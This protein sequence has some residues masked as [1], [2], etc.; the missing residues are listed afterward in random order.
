MI[1]IFL[2][3]LP[4]L[5]AVLPAQGQVGYFTL[6]DGTFRWFEGT[7]M[8]NGV[9]TPTLF[10]RIVDDEGN[11]TRI[12]VHSY[13]PDHVQLNLYRGTHYLKLDT[14]NQKVVS[15]T[16]F[17]ECCV[18]A[19]EGY[20][21]G[22]YQSWGGY[23]YYLVGSS[24][25][26]LTVYKH[27]PGTAKDRST[28]WNTWDFGAALQE[29]AYRFING[30]RR[31]KDEYYWIMYTDGENP[32]STL[33]CSTYQRPDDGVWYYSRLQGNWDTSY[34]CP[35]SSDT[36]DAN[37]QKPAGTAALQMAVAKYDSAATI[38]NR[39]A[40]TGL[41]KVTFFGSYSYNSSAHEIT[42]S[43]TLPV[44]D[45]KMGDSAYVGYTFVPSDNIVVRPPFNKYVIDRQRLGMNSYYRDREGDI[46]GKN[47]VPTK[48]TFYF[49]D[50]H[51][52][53]GGEH[54]WVKST[55]RPNTSTTSLIIDTIRYKL[56]NPSLRYVDL[57][58]KDSVEVNNTMGGGTVKVPVVKLKLRAFPPNKNCELTVYVR[59]AN[60]TED[61]ITRTFHLDGTKAPTPIADPKRGP[62]I[63]GSLFGGGRIANV[64][65]DA[66]VNEDNNVTGG[67]TSITVHNADTIYALYGGNDIAGW[68]QDH[69]T[70]QIGSTFTNKEH[71]VHI[72]YLYGGGCGYYSYENIYDAV[73]GSWAG[74][75]ELSGQGLSYGTY[76]FSGKVYPWG[77]TSTSATPVVDH[78]FDYSPFDDTNFSF[79]L[80]EKGQAGDGTVPYIKSAHI[81]VGV[82]EAKD[83]N[84]IVTTPFLDEEGD[85]TRF[86]NDYI[87]I[88]S[89]FGGAEN[90]FIGVTSTDANHPENGV[91]VDINGGTIYA[92]FGGN[93]YGGSV[94]ENSTV[95]VDVYD[96][97]LGTEEQVAEEDTY[98]TGYGRDFGIRYLFGGG[99]KV[100]GS[101]A[102][103]HIY[104]GMLDTVFLGGN[105][106]SVLNPIGMVECLRYGNDTSHLGD[107]GHFIWTNMTVD[108]TH[109]ELTNL[110]NWETETGR[111]NVKTLFGGNNLAEMSTM[112]FIQL[113]SGGI[114]CI[115]GG[116]N[117]GDMNND[118]TLAD[119]VARGL[120]PPLYSSLL[121]DAF[122]GSGMRVP[123]KVGSI[124]TALQNSNIIA[125]YVF[126]GCRMANVKNSCGM[127]LSGGIFGYVTGGND[128]SGDVGS[129]VEGA[130]TYVVLDSN[131]TVV[132]DVAGGSD[133]FYH[134]PKAG[135][136]EYYD[137]RELYDSYT[138]VNYDPYDEFVGYLRPT[139]N[140]TNV[141]MRGGTV[142]G[143]VIAGGLAADAG[144]S[145]SGNPKIDLGG[146]KANPDDDSDLVPAAGRNNAEV[147]FTMRGGTVKGNVY[148]GGYSSSIFGLSYV[149]VSDSAEIE[150]GL[151]AGNA[152]TGSVEAWGPYLKTNG[153]IDTNKVASDGTPLNKKKT[154]GSGEYENAYAS[155]VL[156][157]G[158]PHI[159][160]LYGSGD[161][162]YDYDGTRP[163]YEPVSTCD[164]ESKLP[165]QKSAFLDIHTSSGAKIDSVFGGGNGVS[166]NENGSVVVLLNCVS[167]TNDGNDVDAI[168]GGNN[169]DNMACV[170]EI[171]LKKGIVGDVYGGSN[172]GSS[173]G[174]VDY[175]L[176]ACSN[177]LPAVSSYVLVEDPNVTITGSVYGGCSS[178][179]VSHMAYVRV[180]NTT[181]RGVDYVYGGNNISGIVEGNTLVEVTG[182]TVHHIYGGSN[183]HY[184][185]VDMGNGYSVYEYNSAHSANTLV[186]EE[187]TGRP[188]VDTASVRIL[189][190]KV[191]NSVF[192]GGRMGDCQVTYVEVDDRTC[193]STGD[194]GAIIYGEVY[195]GGEG[196]WENLN[197]TRRGNVTNSTHV[198]LY[199]AKELT[200]ANGKT[201]AYG[202]GKGGDVLNTYITAHDTWDQSFE[203]LYG[204]SWGSN[205]YGTTHVTINSDPSHLGSGMYSVRNLFG[206]NDFTGNNYKSIIT[207]NSGKFNNVYGGSNGDYPRSAYTTAPYTGTD[208]LR[209]PNSEYIEL[210]FNN[211]TVDSNLYGG[212]KMGTTFTFVKDAH[213]DDLIVNGHKIPD[214][215]LTYTTAHTDPLGYSYIIT[216]IHGGTFKNIFAGARGSKNILRPLV[217]GLKVL[218]MDDGYVHESVYGG[219]ES[220]NDGYTAEC[221][222]VTH[223]TRRPS[224]IVN[225]T[226]GQ[227]SASVYGTGYHGKTSGSAFLNIGIK[228]ID[229]CVAYRAAYRGNSHAYEQFKPGVEGGL[230]PTLVANDLLLDLSVYAG[231]NWGSNTGEADLS[232]SGFF[233][234]E[235]RLIIDGDQYNTAHNSLSPLPL[236]NIHR[237][238]LGSGT[239]VAG[240]DIY[241]S[242]DLRNY[243]AMVNCHPTKKIEAVQRADAFSLHNTAIEYTG[244]TSALSAYIS[245]QYT[246]AYLDTL[247]FRGFNVAEIDAPVGEVGNVYF[248]EDALVS[249]N[250]VKTDREHLN[251]LVPTSTDSSC[252]TTE[253]ICDKILVKQDD[254]NKKYTLL[255]LNNGIDFTVG[256]TVNGVMTYPSP[257]VTGFAYVASP[258]GYSSLLTADA[259]R[260]VVG[261]EQQKGG[262]VSS[263]QWE[264]Q[265][266][267]FLNP[268]E[269]GANFN[270]EW[271]SHDSTAWWV[272]PYLEKIETPYENWSNVYRVWVV[273]E[274]IRLREA[275]LRAHANPEKL[276]D[277]DMS[278]LVEDAGHR[279]HDLGIATTT[280]T[281]PASK[282][283]HYY[284]LDPGGFTL[285]G[286]NA[287][288]VLVDSA[289]S[290]N[291]TKQWSDV[292]ALH[293]SGLPAD[294]FG[295]WNPAEL[296]TST[297]EVL[298]GTT[299]IE[300]A[301][302]TT[303]GLV[304]VPEDKFQKEDIIGSSQEMISAGTVSSANSY[305]YGIES[306]EVLGG[307][308]TITD[309]YDDEEEI[310]LNDPLVE[311]FRIRVCKVE[312]YETIKD[313]VYVQDGTTLVE[314]DLL[315]ETDYETDLECNQYKYFVPAHF[316][317]VSGVIDYN[318]TLPDEAD[319]PSSW[320]GDYSKLE[321]NLVISGNARVN[322]AYPY[323]S[324]MVTSGGM[325]GQIFPKMRLYLTYDKNF[326]STFMGTVNFKLI[327]YDEH[328]NKVGPIDM[329]VYVQTIMED[330]QDIEDNVLAMYNGGRTNTFTRKAILPEVLERRALYMTSIKFTPTTDMGVDIKADGSDADQ[331]FWLMDCEDSVT[332]V[333]NTNNWY[334]HT[335]GSSGVHYHHNRFALSIIPTNNVTEDLSSS[336]G[337]ERIEKDTINVY[338][339]AYPTPTNPTAIDSCRKKNTGWD[340]AKHR[341]ASI[342]LITEE[343]PKGEP[344]GILDGRGSVSLNVQLTYDGTRVYPPIVNKGYVGKM[345][346]GL[347]SYSDDG[348]TNN[349]EMT[350]YVKTRDY[351]DTIYL[352]SAD[353]VV[354]DNC[355]VQ[356]YTHNPKWKYLTRSGSSDEDKRH[357]AEMV[358]KSPNAYVQTFRQALKST[359][360]QE[361]D[362]LCILDTVKTDPASPIVI[363]GTTG[364]AIEVIRYDGH[365]HDFPDEGCVYRGPMIDVKG[366]GSSFTAKNIA[367]HGGAGAKVKHVL[368]DNRGTATTTD[369]TIIYVKTFDGSKDSL[370]TYDSA[371]YYRIPACASVKVP[372]TNCSYA[373]IFLVR[374]TGR[375]AL[376]GGTIVHHNW[377]AYGSGTNQTT[378]EGW[379][380]DSKNMGAI[381]LTTDGTLILTND[382]TIEQNFSHTMPFDMS[383][384]PHEDSLHPGNGAI[385][386]DGGTMELAESTTGTKVSITDNLL[387][388]PLVHS[389]SV[390]WWDT[391]TNDGDIRWVMDT[392]KVRGWK[393]ANVLLT[394]TPQGTSDVLDT[395]SDVITISGSIAPDSRIGVSKW[396]PGPTTRDTI[397]FAQG[398]GSNLTVLETAKD[399]GN[400][401]SDQD[402]NIF[403]SAKVNNANI[404]FQR[405]ATFRHQIASGPGNTLATGE[406][407]GDV[408][409]YEPNLAVSCPTGGDLMIYR[410]QGGF[411]PYQYTWRET[412]GADT[413]LLRDVSTIYSNTLVNADLAAHHYET[414]HAS[415][416]DT[417]VTI[418]LDVADGEGTL[419]TGYVTATDEAGCQMQKNFQV[420]YKMYDSSTDGDYSAFTKTTSPNNGWTD[421]NWSTPGDR[422]TADGVR[423]FKGVQI[424]PKVWA[425]RTKGVIRAMAY[426]DGTPKDT[427]VYTTDATDRLHTLESQR[428]C[429]GDVIRLYTKPRNGHATT[430]KFI[431]WDFDPYY[432]N[433]AQY[434]VPNSDDDV[435]AYY[436]PAN[437]WKDHI[438]NET[439]ATAAYSTNY[440]YTRPAGKGYVT[441]YNG[442]VHI[443]NEEGL[444]WLISVMNGLNGQQ[445]RQFQY[446]TIYLHKKASG[447]Y[448][449]KD[450]LW[451]PMGTVQHKFRGRF[452]G[453]DGGD[454]T[455]DTSTVPL[456]G[457]NR[458]IIKNII[459]N[460][461]NMNNVAF[462]AHLQTA[463]VSGIEL[464]GVL[465]RGG[466]YVGGLVA[467]STNSEYDNVAVTTNG[468]TDAED[469]ASGEPSGEGV[470]T[471]SILTTRYVSGGLIAESNGDKIDH[472]KSWVKY[473]GDAV[474]SG[475]VVGYGTSTTIQNDG[476][477]RNDV[478]MSG[479]YL[480]GVAGHLSGVAQDN[481]R[482]LARLFRRRKAANP[483]VVTN[484]Y[485]E[486][487]NKGLPQM[488]GGLVGYAD[489]TVMENNY[490][491]GNVN[492]SNTSGAV[493]AVMSNNANADKN[494]YAN[495][496]SKYTVGYTEGNASL[497]HTSSFEGSGNQVILENTVYG[498]NNLTRV[499]NKY[500]RERNADGESF[501]TWRSDL[502]TTNHGYPFFGTPDII[503]AQGT[504]YLE[505]CDE[506]VINGVSY[507]RDSSFTVNFIDSVEMVDSTLTAH[508]VLHQS[509]HT[510]VSDT[511]SLETGY[512]GYGFNLTSEELRLLE[513]TVDSTGRATLIVTDTFSTI[514]GCDSVVTLT[515][516]YMA[517]SGV[518]E[519]EE[520]APVQIY[521]NP[522]TSVVYVEAKA[523]SHVEVYDNEGR[524]LQDYD[525]YGKD[526]V[527]VDMTM[528]LSGVY[529]IRVH[530]PEEVIIQKVIKER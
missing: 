286:D 120:V 44:L 331:L 51:Y 153:T 42:F 56:D 4:M 244:T 297:I 516:T 109:P 196:D 495:G 326:S 342:S 245:T 529:Y 148:G 59:Y 474:Y 115:Y 285:S 222:D 226:G 446:N 160:Y 293:G 373:P 385:Y 356:P 477:I 466:Q 330:F 16:E 259:K 415:V 421:T 481:P 195:G 213:G 158:K 128:V 382:V 208:T 84:G 224:S 99:N 513:H 61:T 11:E 234:G 57:S 321:T 121:L 380:S 460:E 83:A 209:R 484:N 448:D 108:T 176:D 328:G 301:P 37:F 211:G 93:N 67:S 309:P 70:I 518:V 276:P 233:G 487:I 349:F 323:C 113:H 337:W 520:G 284:M 189:G 413:T 288:I 428:F 81:T 299:E 314:H 6:T 155:Y 239:S 125:D 9:E 278:I 198:D 150:G 227:V 50:E 444:A 232:A 203:A 379:P 353:H 230:S 319:L 116:G 178:G 23:N 347:C 217:Y 166:V 87:F 397:A 494:Y 34:F 407:A 202:G 476:P 485:I 510:E 329:K 237:S 431:M 412:T 143:V 106:A 454:D 39:P 47:G 395:K 386:I 268:N 180:S 255:L 361:G 403:Y 7:S 504:Q 449:M 530:T 480:G 437:Y 493:A 136:E 204:G 218:N 508:I 497:T 418:K 436:G 425:D 500:V 264:N 452:I 8:D 253:N 122:V 191:T 364:P 133:G 95:Y 492:G 289:W 77:T 281:L 187:T 164:W 248:Y 172:N 68:V 69:A 465:A 350:I 405:C 265:Y 522:T 54:N 488:M 300:R 24:T 104:G 223:S 263:C 271:K 157:D 365:H 396:F 501:R 312:D 402:F 25:T 294:G 279:P 62:V 137:D 199:H 348:D 420:R 43:D 458:V 302:A 506:V 212:G 252:V 370:V 192:G 388:N 58:L 123:T 453:V 107:K 355:L 75:D 505:G 393:K 341:A 387:M 269:F 256:K 13:D 459:L 52:F 169:V 126:G 266:Q 250:L 179:D 254:D 391:V 18:W 525:A 430:S 426:Y 333:V 482:G 33:S 3:L 352:A 381:S 369:D 258:K 14:T 181:A 398:V 422:K 130:G 408:L 524:V 456:T 36:N 260:S 339:L 149:H 272:S 374:D 296:N 515:L 138:F 419:H 514:Y 368:I 317:S 154:D 88:D 283:G 257:G 177:P 193:G 72:G 359:V 127:Y 80:A 210:T 145:A 31:Y 249:D 86:H 91:S 112:S 241:S 194:A 511:A 327:E 371:H 20:P 228:A 159:H 151:F 490:V 478:R 97:K 469:P 161:G 463:E 305:Y 26:P 470:S 73:H 366:A 124:V 335:A 66:G 48:D 389:S 277:E 170:P 472:S 135:K 79:A 313:K 98:Y 483:S 340:D 298:E 17:D 103:T 273:G 336:M 45:M 111:Y 390:A 433:P 188:D 486:V 27:L 287:A 182:G 399:S 110:E 517:N 168:F 400:F 201:Y 443:Y 186:A 214:T 519:V 442:D 464:Q 307:I 156:V 152:I 219:S 507:T 523:M 357:A 114:S 251:A 447:D 63:R 292:R 417:F 10:R 53:G 90:A 308:V 15:T 411:F 473:V 404:Y 423:K 246:M 231:A 509:T 372:D 512:S 503:P 101:Y 140:N 216:N 55:H 351:G 367:F 311:N 30:V 184:D 316:G 291:P 40:N 28:N 290:K 499:L 360:Y 242:I 457:N 267:A 89:L 275:A 378:T 235:S 243:G 377:N 345:V 502:E 167:D 406:T 207:I 29:S 119:G 94:A 247:R 19:L 324:P 205:V 439:E 526:Q 146:N 527:V 131:V 344:L 489:N 32:W 102:R 441:A 440:Y 363:Q 65:Y 325:S 76:C 144:F 35:K 5:L 334:P 236:L 1:K 295:Q 96:T 49:Y 468:F 445:L 185:Y 22:Y 424:T 354:R 434:V 197:H 315:I 165:I 173:T 64:G 401:I 2:L 162:A 471:T 304:M 410:V 240:G 280:F 427:V 435:V 200:S 479:L 118:V 132:A 432:S 362:V 171:R 394:R 346:L 221:K 129:R 358:G 467:R 375:V 225:L 384:D 92:V 220:V 147:H 190:G 376:S 451:Y 229:S 60:G 306:V 475:G 12:E 215:S 134:C 429:E 183:G 318:Y 461:P 141:Y 455:K 139:H 320:Q 496:S 117:A 438:T 332:R 270:T 274:G 163:W 100:D 71:P 82:A 343:K 282:N 206:G 498:I 46:F 41:T 338:R 105:S 528:Y 174:K 462:F 491:F 416:A 303:F 262:F 38:V 310:D 409:D 450:Y 74:S 392:A 142:L 322:N 521:P 238:I 175:V 78:T 261:T 85:S 414:Y 383:G 21:G